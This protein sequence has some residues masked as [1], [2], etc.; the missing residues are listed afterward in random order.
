MPISL[1][2]SIMVVRIR[3]AT[4][5][6]WPTARVPNEPMRRAR[7]TTADGVRT[8]TRTGPDLTAAFQR[9]CADGVPPNRALPGLTWAVA[10]ESRGG[11]S[12]FAVTA[13][14]VM[15]GCWATRWALRAS[16]GYLTGTSLGGGR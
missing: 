6:G 9:P 11:Q 15:A 5:V 4:T 8:A 7:R 10:A 1:R 3:T 16:G 12:P 13:G 14:A 2:S